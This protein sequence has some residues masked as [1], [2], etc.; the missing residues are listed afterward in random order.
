MVGISWGR[1][2]MMYPPSINSHSSDTQ[3]F[4]GSRTTFWW[5]VDNCRF[6]S[7]EN[8]CYRKR[9]DFNWNKIFRKHW[10]D[11]IYIIKDGNIEER[12]TGLRIYLKH[13]LTLGMVQ[14]G[15]NKGN[16]G[17]QP[18]DLSTFLRVLTFS[19]RSRSKIRRWGWEKLWKRWQGQDGNQFFLRSRRVFEDKGKFRRRSEW[20]RAWPLGQQCPM[21]PNI[22]STGGT[23][24]V[25]TGTNVRQN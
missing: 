8:V 3:S 19:A 5:T 10:P 9:S 11:C 20:F 15:P 1:K 13:P 23:K 25:N 7:S 22:Q 16:S 17:I 2:G 6:W 12:S 4:Q 18:L 14:K 21:Q 24:I